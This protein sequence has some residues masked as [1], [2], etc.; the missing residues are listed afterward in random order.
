M[1]RLDN[2]NDVRFPQFDP[3]PAMEKNLRF[4]EAHQ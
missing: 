1:A 2:D 4:I 3:E